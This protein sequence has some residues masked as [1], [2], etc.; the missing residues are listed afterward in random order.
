V[1][2]PECLSSGVSVSGQSGGRVWASDGVSDGQVAFERGPG[3]GDRLDG[4]GR[5]RW[6]AGCGGVAVG[7]VV[8]AG[9]RDCGWW[10]G[11]RGPQA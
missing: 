8:V 1:R 11:P 10:A 7:V 3:C 4:G 5:G 9:A 2:V 6:T